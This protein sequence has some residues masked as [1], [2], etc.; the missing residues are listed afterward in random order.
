MTAGGQGE[1][2]SLCY[3]GDSNLSAQSEEH[4]QRRELRP[5][6]DTRRTGGRLEG[7]RDF[8]ASKVTI[9]HREMKRQN[10]TRE[11]NDL[12]RWNMKVAVK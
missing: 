11:T 2:R 8:T 5:G 4:E 7:P 1:S 10:S 12:E 9:F 3:E 6:M